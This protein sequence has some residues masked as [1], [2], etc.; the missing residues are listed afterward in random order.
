MAKVL[1]FQG[2]YW[3]STNVGVLFSGEGIGHGDHLSG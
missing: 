2:H 1:A 3:N